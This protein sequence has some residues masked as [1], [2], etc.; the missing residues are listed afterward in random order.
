MRVR[1]GRKE[2]IIA[3]ELIFDLTDRTKD[4]HLRWPIDAHESGIV[5]LLMLLLLSYCFVN[6]TKCLLIE[7]A[8]ATTIKS[9]LGHNWT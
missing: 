7:L 8:K 5:H 9:N 6:A 2:I 1:E 3:L 4:A